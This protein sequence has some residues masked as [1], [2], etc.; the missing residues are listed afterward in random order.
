MPSEIVLGN[1][2]IRTSDIIQRKWMD[3]NSTAAVASVKL[4]KKIS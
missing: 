1:D 2:T 4:P 3:N